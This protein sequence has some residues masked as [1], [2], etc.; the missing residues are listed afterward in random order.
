MGWKFLP[1]DA[2]QARPML[3]CGVRLF[4]CLS[5]TFVNSVETS[6]GSNHIC[7]IFSPSCSHSILVF[8]HQTSWKYSAGNPLTGASNA[9]RVG[10]NRDSE[11]I[12]GSVAWCEPF[13][14]QVQYTRLRLTM[15]S[16]CSLVVSGEVCWWR[17][18]TTKCVTRRLDV[19]PKTTEQH[20]IIRSGRLNLMHK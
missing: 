10:K 9:G 15:A 11:S 6:N 4:V 7:K 1:H 19:T 13:E 16:W 17:E 12:A 3:S 2:M 20:L 18:T 14:R 8:P 5:V